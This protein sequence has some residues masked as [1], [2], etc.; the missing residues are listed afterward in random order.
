MRLQLLLSALSILLAASAGAEVRI[1]DR[2]ITRASD[3]SEPSVAV[4]RCI[5]SG[6]AW[7]SS[8]LGSP[9]MYEFPSEVEFVTAVQTGL[10]GDPLVLLS[11]LGLRV[12][13]ARLVELSMADLRTLMAADGAAGEDAVL[14]AQ[15]KRVLQENRWLNQS[16]LAIVSGFLSGLGV[17]NL[18]ALQ[19]LA[20][21]DQ[22]AIQNLIQSVASVEADLQ[23]EA[24]AYAGQVATNPVE[25]C[26]YFRFYLAVAAQAGA[27]SPTARG[28]QAETVRSAAGAVLVMALDGPSVSGVPNS[29]SLR[30]ALDAWFAQGK[31]LGFDRLSSGLLQMARSMPA[32]SAMDL[33]SFQRSLAQTQAGVASL[34][35]STESSAVSASQFGEEYQFRY[36]SGVESLTVEVNA[37]GR[38]SLLSRN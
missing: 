29:R 27:D 9:S 4:L 20:L 34:L 12:H 30:A 15:S 6:D 2:V 37:Q 31:A 33:S 17:Q 23:N 28:R 22:A 25:F 11:G 24:A 10:H 21:A 1:A 14:K 38:V 13:V 8:A 35:A 32:G 7:L 19:A 36:E 3:L 18:P 16:D 5:E 26:D